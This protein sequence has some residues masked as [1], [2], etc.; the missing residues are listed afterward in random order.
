[1]SKRKLPLY[2]D[3][4]QV[5][6]D[7]LGRLCS[8]YNTE[9]NENFQPNDI[10]TYSLTQYIGEEGCK[11]FNRPG[12]FSSLSP[13]KGAKET[14]FDLLARG[15]EIFI[16]SSPMNEHCVFEKYKWIKD[17]IPFFPIK[18]LILVGNKGDLLE[19]IGN[20]ILLDDCPEYI[21]KF[22]GITVV[23]DMAYN[24]DI[25]CDFRVSNWDEFFKVVEWVN[26]QYQ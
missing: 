20:G 7:F 17:Y 10:K 5:I 18:N 12:F 3:M 21:S 25:E 4:D 23:M 1:M 11:I 6:C 8:I 16:V 9:Y 24:Q 22:K 14:I 13:I 15:Y 26:K 19:R 2:I